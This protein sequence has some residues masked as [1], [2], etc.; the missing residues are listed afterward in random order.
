MGSALF[1]LVVTVDCFDA[2]PVST[3]VVVVVAVVVAVCAVVATAL[4]SAVAAA[5]DSADVALDCSLQFCSSK[6]RY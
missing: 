4:D 2:T 3:E 1:P 5:F 6:T